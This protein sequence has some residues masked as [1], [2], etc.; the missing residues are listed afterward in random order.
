MIDFSF[1]EKLVQLKDI[2]ISSPFFFISLIVAILLLIV[3]IISIKKNRRIHKLIF[4]VAWLFIAIFVIVR[5]HSALLLVFDRF[6]GRIVEEIYFPSISVYTILFIFNNILLI[7]S[8]FSKKL[9]N[10][11]RISNIVF[12]M[13]INLLFI[14]FLDIIIRNNIDISNSLQFYSNSKVLVLLELSMFV[15]VTWMLI[16]CLLYFIN[17]FGLKK[18]YVDIYKDEDYELLEIPMNNFQTIEEIID[19][20]DDL[21]TPK[22]EIEIL[23]I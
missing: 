19:I 22:E 1:R 3:M 10:V 9:K 13:S 15:F 18:V 2:I 23:D 6:F 5:Y 16:S 11:Y 21:I 8:I 12:A 14:L 20:D 17:R 7:Y 4:A